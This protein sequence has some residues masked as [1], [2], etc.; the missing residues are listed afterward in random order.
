MVEHI[1]DHQGRKYLRLI[2]G[3]K[4]DGSPAEPIRVDV[5]R[6]LVAFGVTCPATAH[7]V[8]KLLT[9]GERGKGSR[10]DDLVGA[11]AALSRAIEDERE[12]CQGP[13]PGV[14]SDDLDFLCDRADSQDQWAIGRLKYLAQ[15]EDVPEKAVYY[16]SSWQAVADLIRG[17]RSVKA[18][19]TTTIRMALE[20]D[21]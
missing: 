18:G 8:K 14:A 16:A 11:D 13:P 9:A 15:Q 1:H 20:E 21:R 12:R 17:A 4:E 7:A 2:R 10:L 19:Q 5:Y 3:W 6:V